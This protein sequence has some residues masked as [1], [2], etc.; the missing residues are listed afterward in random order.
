[1]KIENYKFKS[2]SIKKVFRN[3]LSILSYL[4]CL[5]T[6]EYCKIF[7]STGG[8]LK[9][10]INSIIN[11]PNTEL[12]NFVT[13]EK[14]NKIIGFCSGYPSSEIAQRQL[15]TILI[16]RNFINI[17][18]RKFLIKKIK[19]KIDLLPPV[20]KKSFYISRN[21]ILPRYHGIGAGKI[22]LK[23]ICKKHLNFNLI[24]IHV[25]NSNKIAK[26]FYQIQKFKK[27]TNKNHYSL[28]IKRLKK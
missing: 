23:E 8:N 19:N 17:K 12:E 13:I 21:A 26:N 10:F 25:K 18:K 22:L 3:N 15:K 27:V 7:K 14:S 20:N 24:S 4:F 2:Y 11:K 28:Y 9:K 6:P 1:M 16:M 5:A